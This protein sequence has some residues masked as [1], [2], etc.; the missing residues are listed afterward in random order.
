MAAGTTPQISCSRPSLVAP[1]SGV[2]VI[3]CSWWCARKTL[4]HCEP[5]TCLLYATSPQQTCE[6]SCAMGRT[7]ACLCVWRCVH[8]D[9]RPLPALTICLHPMAALLTRS[10]RWWMLPTMSTRRLGA[11]CDCTLEPTT[12]SPMTRLSEIGWYRM[13][14]PLCSSHALQHRCQCTR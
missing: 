12:A 2:Q 7:L 4:P 10:S 11:S 3:A 6:L 9:S 14:L 8:V 5:W 1:L 13:S